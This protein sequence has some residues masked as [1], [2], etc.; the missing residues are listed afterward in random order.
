[1]RD[2][3][4]ID[5]VALDPRWENPSEDEILIEGVMV[6]EELRPGLRLHYC[7]TVEGHPFTVSSS[8]EEGLSCVVFLDGE[9]DLRIDEQAHRFRREGGGR[10]NATAF[11]SLMAEQFT[12]TT[13]HR[14]KCRHLVVTASREW[15]DMDG[16]GGL[17]ERT[18]T[19]F[20]RSHLAHKQWD[21][22]NRAVENV[23]RIAG[24]IAAPSA[25]S[26][27]YI[28]SCA[29]ELIAETIAALT[30]T[31]GAADHRANVRAKAVF[32]RARE[33]IDQHLSGD[34][35]IGGIARSAGTSDSVLQRLF[36]EFE[37]QTVFEYIRRRRLELAFRALASDQ[38]AIK[39]AAQLAGY[40]NASNFATAFKRQ[41]GFAPSAVR[42]I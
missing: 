33:F 24:Q 23:S 30:N 40:R 16:P 7:D 38:M 4:G 12:R 21:L 26:R 41:F 10:L 27:L 34:I 36:H 17:T 15:L 3:V 37:D 1:M 20:F 6:Q 28:E 9:V 14:Q 42:R 29:V 31:E 11:S 8:I 35:S 18:A 25:L 2:F 39:E 19:S 5:G 13:P 22:S 32:K